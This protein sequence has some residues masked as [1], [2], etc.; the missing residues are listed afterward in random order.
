MQVGELAPI[1]SN[2][3][4]LWGSTHGYTSYGVPNTDG[5]RRVRVVHRSRLEHCRCRL[6]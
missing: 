4:R 6:K 3:P 2:G 1:A 5:A